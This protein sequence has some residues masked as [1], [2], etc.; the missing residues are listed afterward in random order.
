MQLVLQNATSSK[1]MPLATLYDKLDSHLRSLE[2]LGVTT[3]KCGAMLIPLVVESSLLEDLLRAWERSNMKGFSLANSDNSDSTRRKPKF[4]GEKR[5]VPSANSLIVKGE[6]LSCIFC[7]RKGHESAKCMKAR[8][9]PYAEKQD[10]ARRQRACFNCL[11]SGHSYSTCRV[12]VKCSKFAR[13]HVHIMCFKDEKDKNSVSESVVRNTTSAVNMQ[14]EHNLAVSSEV[15]RTFIKTLKIK[16]RSDTSEVIVRA[17]IDT[18][19]QNSYILKSVA[20][21]LKYKQIGKQELVHLLFG[22]DRSKITTH[23]RYLIRAG[24]L[25]GGYWCNFQAL[26]QEMI[27]AVVPTVIEGKWIDELKSEKISLSDV[28]SEEKS[29]AVLIGANVA[30]KLLTSRLHTLAGGLTAVETRLGRTL[31]GKVP[32]KSEDDLN[33]AVTAISMFVKEADIKDLWSLGAIGIRDPIEQRLKKDTEKAT[34]Q[35]LL[36]NV[37]M[38]EEGQYEVKM[39]W[40]ENYPPLKDNKNVAVKKLQSTARNLKADRLF[41]DYDAVFQDWLAEGIIEL[42]PVEQE[43]DWGRYLPHRHVVKENSTTFIRPVY[44]ASDKEEESPSI[45]D[46]VEKGVTLIELIAD[47]LLLFREVME[48]AS[49]DLRGWKYTHDG[50]EKRQTGVFEILWDKSDD[51]LSI[52]VDFAEQLESDKVT[53]KSILSVANRIFDPLGFMSPVTLC[54]RLLLQET[55]AQNLSWDEVVKSDRVSLHTFCDASKDAYAAVVFLS[56]ESES[57]VRVNL[58]QGK[59]R[60]APARKGNSDARVSIPRLE[61]LAATIAARLTAS[62]LESFKGRKMNVCCW[63]DSSTVLTWIHEESNWA[64]FVWNRFKEIHSLSSADQWRHVPG[65]MNPADLPSRGCTSDQLLISR[66]WEG[67][68]WLKSKPE[69]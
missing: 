11:K 25:D 7:E 43:K 52:K 42:V 68:E 48:S 57:G 18:G 16:V 34:K 9:M 30:G 5:D 61:L 38:S 66:W 33:M 62:V 24:N 28:C 49:F 36:N 23:A 22:G 27:C 20:S 31:M 63:S 64:T 53:K 45:N 46:C 14:I 2:T 32:I 60:V 13:R 44:N 67:S 3:E 65:H 47:I 40:L 41:E 51:T 6:E 26:D 69:N 39:P 29:V 37:I 8:N 59:S 35:A 58:V 15:P 21:T 56:V 55:W 12:N 54:P 10:K 50:A 17:V 19:S 4:S 1:P